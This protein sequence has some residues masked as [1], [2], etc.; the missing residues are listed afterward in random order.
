MNAFV[1]MALVPVALLA[2][3]AIGARRQRLDPRTDLGLQLPTARQA[4]VALLLFLLLSTA[5]ELLYRH[6]A[7]QPTGEPWHLRYSPPALAVRLAFVALVFPV[8]EEI[9]FRGFLFGALGRRWGDLVAI[10]GSSVLFAALHL[11][12]DLRG[13][14]LVFADAIFFA[15]VRARTRSTLL[16][17]ALHMLGNGY[18][19]WQRY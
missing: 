1:L 10:A 2:G 12:Y 4:A 3:S 8:A 17:I 9:F 5:S 14:A 18:A 15:L 6:W 19:A 16:T 13:M 7:L 11:Q